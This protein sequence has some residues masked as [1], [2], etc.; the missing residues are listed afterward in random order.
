MPVMVTET[1]NLEEQ[2]PDMKA[3]LAR[4]LKEN[5]EKDA[6]IKL[7]SKQIVDLAK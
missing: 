4:L 3:I 6:Q 1:I 2:L 7:Q 5:A